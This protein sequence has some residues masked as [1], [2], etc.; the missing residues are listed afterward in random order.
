MKTEFPIIT[1]TRLLLRQFSDAD[2]PKVFEGLSHPKVIPY[3]G[4]SFDTIEATKEQIKWF[5]DIEQNGTGI[6]WAVCS[7]D[8]KK[9]YGAGG[10]NSISSE[11]RKA[12][13][14]FWLLPE[15]W[16][17]GI[18]KETMPLIVEYGFTRLGLHRIEGLVESEN[19]NC[20]N[21]MAKLDFQY[22]GT[23]RDCEVKNGKYISLDIYAKLGLPNLQ[24]AV[25]VKLPPELSQTENT[26]RPAT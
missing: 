23:M 2:L 22:E 10:L 4:V 24:Q 19:K 3:Y 20:K 25:A 21:A 15:Y 11:H 16:G 12:E 9:F 18:M 6:W 5:A 13:I 14:G 1:T 26:G 8:N 7:A 17:L